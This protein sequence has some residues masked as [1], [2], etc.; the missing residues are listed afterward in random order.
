M[1]LD[2]YLDFLL[3]GNA[4]QLGRAIASWREGIDY[5]RTFW[6]NWFATSGSNWPDEFNKR[7]APRPL[8]QFAIDRLPVSGS[9]K[10]LDIGAGPATNVGDHLPG[11]E[12]SVVPLDPLAHIYDDIIR[13]GGGGHRS[14]TSH[15]VR[16]CRRPEREN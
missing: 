12:I 13:G 7:M 16:I 11:R 3:T 14:A 15:A 8:Q 10:M 5:E 9:V 1:R 2:A 6:R 4:A